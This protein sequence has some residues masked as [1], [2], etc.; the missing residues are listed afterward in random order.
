MEPAA[1][2][3]KLVEALASQELLE[4]YKMGRAQED[5]CEISIKSPARAL[6]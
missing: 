1:Q 2:F 3:A 6:D 5:L 4:R